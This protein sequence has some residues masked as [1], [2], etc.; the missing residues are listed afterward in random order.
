[1]VLSPIAPE[2]DEL[3][4]PALFEVYKAATELYG[5]VH[6][7]Y[8]QSPTGLAIMREFFLSGRFGTCPRVLCERSGALPIGQSEELH[9]NRVKLYCPKCQE[10]YIPVNK[11]SDIDGAYFGTSFPH[12]LL[13]TYPDLH[14]VKETKGYVRRIFGF[15]V[16]RSKFS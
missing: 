4:D 2:E 10:V 7:R 16:K 15:K 11:Y 13:A 14:P 1:M 9:H 12:M 5:L 3:T 6:A 8:I